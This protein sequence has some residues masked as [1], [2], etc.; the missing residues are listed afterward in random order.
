EQYPVAAR[1]GSW[2]TRGMPDNVTSKL[3]AL[4]FYQLAIPTPTPPAGS[5]GGAGGPG[6]EGPVPGKAEWAA[7]PRP[8]A[9]TAPG[10]NVHTPAEIGID[11]FQADRSPTH[12]Y[13]TAPLAGLWS[14][15]T[16]GFYHDGRFAT[17]TDVVKHYDTLMGLNLSDAETRQLVEYLKS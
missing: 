13:R 4:H 5:F 2:N 14:R 11:S 8:P 6:G 15:P 16:R 10:H 1:T 12:A 7:G 3:A 17:L 9:V